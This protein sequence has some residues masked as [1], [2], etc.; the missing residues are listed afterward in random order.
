MSY[1]RVSTPCIPLNTSHICGRWTLT[2]VV[3]FSHC[4]SLEQYFNVSD[5]L[6]KIHQG[7]VGNK[8]YIN[9]TS[10]ELKVGAQALDREQLDKYTLVVELRSNG[11]NKGFAVVRHVL[12]LIT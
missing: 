4:Q 11:N 12:F 6:F 2:L 5:P 3:C 10:K 9:G 8:F 7:G 1:Y